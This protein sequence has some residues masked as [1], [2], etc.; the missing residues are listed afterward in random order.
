MKIIR[1]ND[2]IAELIKKNWDK[3]RKELCRQINEVFKTGNLSREIYFS[4]PNWTSTCTILWQ[5]CIRDRSK[6]QLFT[7]GFDIFWFFQI[8]CCDL[9]Q[10]IGRQ[11]STPSL[12]SLH[13][14]KIWSDVDLFCFYAE[15]CYNYPVQKL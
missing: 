13:Y 11:V 10:L 4:T 14:S 7:L 6:Y 15:I 8:V 9:N 2:I 12:T 3:V 1:I 5:M